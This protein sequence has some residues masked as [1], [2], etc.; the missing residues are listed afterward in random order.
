VVPRSRTYIDANPASEESARLLDIAPGF[1][2]L[3][4]FYAPEI[5]GSNMGI[6]GMALS[7]FDRMGIMIE[8]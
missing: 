5:E 2:M 1:P 7:P 8:R 6:Y 4:R 3:R